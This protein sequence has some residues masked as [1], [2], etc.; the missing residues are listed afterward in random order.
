MRNGLFHLIINNFHFLAGVEFSLSI[1]DSSDVKSTFGTFIST[2]VQQ[3]NKIEDLQDFIKNLKQ[4]HS[5]A[6]LGVQLLL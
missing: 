6:I 4:E 5:K 1:P 3:Q 2:I